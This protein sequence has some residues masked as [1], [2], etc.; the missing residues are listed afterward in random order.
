M[1]ITPYLLDANRFCDWHRQ[2]IDS[3]NRA[4]RAWLRELTWVPGSGASSDKNVPVSHFVFDFI[5][6]IIFVI[7]DLLASTGARAYLER[8]EQSLYS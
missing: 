3:S 4:Q 1:R 7:A 2:K 8:E 5:F 6:T